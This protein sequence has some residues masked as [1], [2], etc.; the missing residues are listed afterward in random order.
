MGNEKVNCTVMADVGNCDDK[1]SMCEPDARVGTQGV[2]YVG[3]SAPAAIAAARG[4]GFSA[5]RP[6]SRPAG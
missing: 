3:A 5:G 2:Q 1:D 4:L 6:P